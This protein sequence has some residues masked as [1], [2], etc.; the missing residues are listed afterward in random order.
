MQ[1]QTFNQALLKPIL[2][3]SSKNT[4][5]S[6]NWLEAFLLTE[7]KLT[8]NGY[9][10]DVYSLTGLESTS[11]VTEHHKAHASKVREHWELLEYFENSKKSAA[12]QSNLNISWALIF[13]ISIILQLWIWT[14]Y[15][16]LFTYSC[17]VPTDLN[18][19]QTLQRNTPATVG[20]WSR[21]CSA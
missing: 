18:D 9:W 11:R 1:G 4:C 16:L 10:E 5:S 8:R 21:V 2:N 15:F 14:W 17:W 7:T 19:F 12:R 20:K 6:M 13:D 3:A